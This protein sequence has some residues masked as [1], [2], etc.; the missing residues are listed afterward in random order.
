MIK[1]GAVAA[2]RHAP[3]SGDG[4]LGVEELLKDAARVADGQPLSGTPEESGYEY[5]FPAI[6]GV[7][8]GRT[9]FA[10]MCPLK[11]VAKMFV[12]DEEE[13]RPELRAQRSLN[14]GRIPEMSRYLIDNPDGYV[15]SAL[16]VSVDGKIRFSP[17]TAQQGPASLLGTLRVPMD[18]TFVIN[19][20]QHRQA[21]IREAIKQRP[22]LGEETIAVVVFLDLGLER[23][24]QMFADLNRHAVRPS[25][26]IG[27]LYDQRDGH[28][29]LAKLLVLRSPVFKGVVEMEASSLS[30]ASRKLFTLSA[31]HGATRTLLDG[32]PVEDEARLALATRYWTAI[33][34]RLPKWA[35]VRDGRARSG[36]V[37]AEY[38]HTHGIVLTALARV[39]NTLLT[40]HGPD[41]PWE[42][43]LDGLR[44]ID[45]SRANRLWEGRALVGGQVSKARN[46]VLLTT[47]AVRSALGLPLPAD[48]SRAQQAAAEVVA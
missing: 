33:D 31:I 30:K 12:Y 43:A 21:A 24:Q 28:A 25:K 18:A 17:H 44:S 20:G 39:G 14:K 35:E 15:F 11:I 8:A 9:F 47:A 36:D 40:E 6:R 38:I 29:G 37:R 32:L 1:M 34:E 45:W 27:V 19:D 41:G 16:T 26:S 3:G 42:V 7:Q 46:N 48:E 5:V 10:T 13:L 22:E 2:Q 4:G 23:C